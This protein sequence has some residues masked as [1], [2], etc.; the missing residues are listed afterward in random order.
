[1]TLEINL[2]HCKCIARVTK[3]LKLDI[4]ISRSNYHMIETKHRQE[5][6]NKNLLWNANCEPIQKQVTCHQYLNLHLNHYMFMSKDY[7]LKIKCTR[8]GG[9]NGLIEK[10]TLNYYSNHEKKHNEIMDKELKHKK[11]KTI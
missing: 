4:H 8:G 10:Y 1:M 11:Y 5:L 3:N 2:G 9:E 7:Y 6:L